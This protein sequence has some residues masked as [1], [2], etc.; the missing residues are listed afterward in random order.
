MNWGKQ[1]KKRCFFDCDIR[2][3]IGVMMTVGIVYLDVKLGDVLTEGLQFYVFAVIFT[4]LV[5]K[6]AIDLLPVLLQRRGR[7]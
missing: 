4:M 2:C 3:L 7:R 6:Q 5:P 1:E